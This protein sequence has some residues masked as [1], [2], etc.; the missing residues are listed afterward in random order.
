MVILSLSSGSTGLVSEHME[1]FMMDNRSKCYMCRE[2]GFTSV[3]PDSCLDLEEQLT[4]R[5]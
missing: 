3:G 1:A 5:V 4:G 2:I